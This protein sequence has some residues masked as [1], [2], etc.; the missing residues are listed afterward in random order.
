MS[1]STRSPQ[2]SKKRRPCWSTRSCTD[3]AVET[4][5]GS[6]TRR[7]WKGAMFDWHSSYRETPRIISKND[8]LGE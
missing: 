2:P 1:R 5:A 4:S 3:G 7:N 6:E 8:D